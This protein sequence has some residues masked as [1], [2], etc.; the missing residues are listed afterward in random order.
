M[1]VISLMFQLSCCS[2][3]AALGPPLSPIVFQFTISLFML[4]N[5]VVAP[6]P[7]ILLEEGGVAA[8][9]PQEWAFYAVASDSWSA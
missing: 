3:E 9:E 2:E 7:E 5:A 1:F 6:N 4:P 8:S